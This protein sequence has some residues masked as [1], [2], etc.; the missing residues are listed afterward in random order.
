MTEK[1]AEEDLLP[2]GRR[3]FDITKEVIE[4]AERLAS[5]GLI[6]SQIAL[7]MGIVDSTL[8]EKQALHPELAEAIK[9]GKARGIGRIAN[10][11]FD[12][13]DEGDFPAQKFYLSNRDPDNWG[14]IQRRQYLDANG[15]TMAPPHHKI[16]IEVVDPDSDNLE[17][18]VTS[19]E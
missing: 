19:E 6:M 15:D 2:V 10:R 13:A 9:R 12:K 5:H 8:Y 7:V 3:K 14:E 1:K 16:Q 11:L 18:N 4:K 17:A